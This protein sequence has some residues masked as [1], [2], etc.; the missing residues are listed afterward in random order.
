MCTTELRPMQPVRSL[1]SCEE[2]LVKFSIPTPKSGCDNRGELVACRLNPA[3][4]TFQDEPVVIVE[5]ISESTRRT[6]EN[7][8]RDAYLSIDSLQQY[9][10]VESSTVAAIVYRRSDSGFTRESHIGNEAIFALPEI[11]CQLSLVDVF[12]KVEFPPPKSEDELD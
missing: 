6:N 5:V 12:E 8:K 4:D 10:L 1:H 3:T 2:S 7:E 9:I 11:D